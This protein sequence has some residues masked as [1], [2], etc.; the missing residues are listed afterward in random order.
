MRPM[1]SIQSSNK[2]S[3]PTKKN[4]VRFDTSTATINDYDQR[5]TQPWSRI[6]INS[7]SS[8]VPPHDGFIR[9]LTPPNDRSIITPNPAEPPVIYRSSTIIYTR[10]KHNYADGGELRTWSV[11]DHQHHTKPSTSIQILPARIINEFQYQVGNKQLQS[12]PSISEQQR[13]QAQYTLHR[14]PGNSFSSQ[15]NLI[16]IFS[17]S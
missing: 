2:R 1:G 13:V 8:C 9:P 10:D 11:Q 14:Y 4:P 3:S 15:K 5:S 12:I 17:F 6:Q 16:K 7:S